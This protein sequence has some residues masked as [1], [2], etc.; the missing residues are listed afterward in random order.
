MLLGE[1]H[2]EGNDVLG[3]FL[4]LRLLGHSQQGGDVV[5]V[6]R[7]H[8]REVRVIPEIV[9]AVR[10]PLSRSGL[11]KRCTAWTPS[12][13]EQPGIRPGSVRRDGQMRKQLHELTT[14][15]EG[16]DAGQV[17]LHRLRSH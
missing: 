9:L 5:L 14:V 13:P 3:G 15:G 6:R 10:Q 2:L 8:F 7:P 4:R 12:H 1:L 11:R 17:R 16:G